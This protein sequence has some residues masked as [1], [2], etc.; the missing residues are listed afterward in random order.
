MRALMID[1]HMSQLVQ[2][3]KLLLHISLIISICG[4]NLCNRRKLFV[5]VSNASLVL[6]K[7]MFH[8]LQTQLETIAKMNADL[9]RKNNTHKKQA[10]TLLE[11][12]SDL[13]T[14]LCEKDIEVTLN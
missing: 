8:Q 4:N 3:I 11:E 10:R 2:T 5:D 1:C 7:L 14:Q 6:S 9:R 12:K 13:E